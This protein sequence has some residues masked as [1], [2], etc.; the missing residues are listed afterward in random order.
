MSQQEFFQGPQFQEQE[1]GRPSLEDDE[2]EYPPQPYYWS[3]QPGK[4]APKDEPTSLSDESMVEA[5][6]PGDY[7]HGYAAQDNVS[8]PIGERYITPTFNVPRE[9]SNRGTP[10]WQS[11]KQRQQFSHDG[12]SFEHQYLPYRANNQQWSAPPWARPQHRRG[13][14]RWFWLVVLG[15][16]FMGPLLHILGAFLAVIGVIILTLLVPFLLVAMFALP[17]M[18]FRVIRGR[19]LPGRRWPYTSSLRG[20]WRW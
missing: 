9:E 7:Q 14:A 6:H 8:N 15:L 4:G 5:D 18:L 11:Q 20:P 2:I 10:Q 3:T 12:D 16:L 17:Y 13:A 1:Q 19:P